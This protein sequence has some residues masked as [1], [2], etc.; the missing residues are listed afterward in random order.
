MFPL[1]RTTLP[2]TAADLA[3]AINNSLRSTFALSRDP[4]EVR[5]LSYP[6]LA[7]IEV[8][9]DGA[10]LPGR[11]PE[12]P[13]LASPAEPALT[14]GSFKAGGRGISVGP[15]A[16]DFALTASGVELNQAKDNAGQIVLLLHNAAQGHVEAS[17][18]KSDLE[19]LIA[20]VA[21]TEAGKHGVNI[22]NVQLSLRSA[23]PRSLAA[24]VRLDAK[25]LFL[26]AALKLSAQL[27]LDAELNA[28]LS[29]LNCAGDGALATVACNILK[30]HL[31]K[32]NGRAFPLM[33]LPLGEV[34][35]RDVRVAVGERL[36]VTADF[37]SSS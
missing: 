35:L 28:R 16:L 17:V 11:P 22:D 37:G 18:S 7:A 4:A 23:G 31:E 2:T 15:A 26:T 3:Q 27:D 30:P 9:L 8:I 21:K 1:N 5:D 19:A 13:S 6:H 36:S 25:K 32:L 34:R 29:G 10:Q 12:I 24:E 33:S 20:N 14:A